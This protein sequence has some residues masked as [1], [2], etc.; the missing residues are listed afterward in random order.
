MSH[1]QIHPQLHPRSF[2]SDNHA[3][4]H[5]D[6]LAAITAAS[7]GDAPAYGADAW[8]LKASVLAQKQFGKEAKFF[9][10]FNGTGANVLSL[11]ATVKTF[12]SV[13]CAAKAH[14]AEDECGA[15]EHFGGFK[16]MLIPTPNCKLTP[17]LIQHEAVDHLNRAGDVHRVQP[18]AISITQSTEYGTLY[19]L[20]EIKALAEFA[21]SREMILHMDGA[22]AANA[23]A[24]LGVSLKA[25]TTDCGVDVLSL[26]GTKNGAMGAEAVVVLNP[27]LGLDLPYLRKQGMQLASKMRF[28][29]AQWVALFE[30]DLWLMNATHANQMARLLAE[31]VANVKGVELTQKTEVNAVFAKLPAKSIE[32]LQKEFLFY[33]WEETADVAAPKVVRWM[34]HFQTTEKDIAAFSAAVTRVLKQIAI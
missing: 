15:P 22:R 14:I 23:A 11:T 34:T 2:A 26:G 25:M 5:P 30:N 20:S 3:G 16:L 7:N 17:E 12:E 27:S 21:H 28:I 31:S 4:V 6:I 1:R 24:A 13:I 33:V 9:P 10:V 19:Q 29:S 18:R 8:T 32:E